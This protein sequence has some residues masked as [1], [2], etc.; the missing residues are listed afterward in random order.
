MI[1]YTPEVLQPMK[2]DQLKKSSSEHQA[3]NFQWCIFGDWMRI[4]ITKPYHTPVGHLTGGWQ[5]CTGDLP[6]NALP[7]TNI[8]VAPEN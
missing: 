1:N 6:S 7:K 4:V 2:R 8:L 5:D 3:V